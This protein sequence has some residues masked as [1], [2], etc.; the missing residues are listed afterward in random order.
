MNYDQ[1]RAVRAA[2]RALAEVQRF[3]PEESKGAL[4]TAMRD[5]EDLA[6]VNMPWSLQRASR[7]LQDAL[8]A[9]ER[10]ASRADKKLH[11]QLAKVATSTRAALGG[12]DTED[13]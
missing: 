8:R 10:E 4:Q 7:D 3:A 12:K 5:L 9:F 13:E 6:R 2:S 11:A 1:K